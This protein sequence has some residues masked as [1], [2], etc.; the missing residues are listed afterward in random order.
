MPHKR[1]KRSV[2]DAER[3][4]TGYNLAPRASDLDYTVA[5]AKA[6]QKAQEIASGVSDGAKRSNKKRKAAS[7]GEGGAK[8]P[9]GYA[10]DDTP[11]NATRVLNA[12]SVQSAYNA[13]KNGLDNGSD[14][15]NGQV[16]KKR[17]L[18]AE[19]NK[20]TNKNS[21]KSA[22]PTILPHESLGDFNRRLEQHLRP[23][24]AQA[25]KEAASKKGAEE[26]D[27]RKLKRENREKAKIQKQEADERRKREEEAE[28]E[29]GDEEGGEGKKRRRKPASNVDDDQ[30][31]EVDGE[32]DVDM[33]DIFDN[34]STHK[35]VP[36]PTTSSAR[37]SSQAKSTSTPTT[38][39]TS[40]TKPIKEFALASNRRS[41]TDVALAPPSLPRLKIVT[42]IS[43]IN[44][45]GG[46]F[47][48]TGRTPLLNA[49]MKRIMEE[50]RE[51][52][53]ARYREIKEEQKVKAEADR[54]ARDALAKGKGGK[55]RTGKRKVM[56]E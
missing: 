39:S 23:G 15:A 29:E 13:K 9:T 32:G 33:D 35:S 44:T 56:E 1:S 55:G 48:P 4:K 34:P 22:L 26:A 3:S 38:D 19:T 6:K 46:A 31:N 41:V 12:F 50:E 18:G 11:R 10:D 37:P 53:I 25:I 42:K 54:A 24:V 8:M 5:A 36:K 21:N 51:R 14:N 16:Q 17:K 45:A 27:A 7:A 2:R 20:K 43:G 52:V 28:A 49:G 30:D 47:A 40:T